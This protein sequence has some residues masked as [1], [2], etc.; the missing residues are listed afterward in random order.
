[1]IRFWGAVLIYAGLMLLAFMGGLAQ[2]II[3]YI[4][5]G[6]VLQPLETV[7]GSVAMIMLA[8]AGSTLLV[9]LMVVYVILGFLAIFGKL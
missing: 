7:G 3:G 9:V 4:A 2:M 8:I 6:N 5:T 1:M